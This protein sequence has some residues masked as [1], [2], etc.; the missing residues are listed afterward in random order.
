M[1]SSTTSAADVARATLDALNA[2]DIDSMRACWSES[3]TE[4]M[5]DGT[6]S[7]AD[8]LAAYFQGLVDALP[9]VS[10]RYEAVVEDGETV[11]LRWHLTGTHTGAPFQGIA[12]TGKAVA[13][14]GMDHMTIRDGK[15]V[16]NFVVFDRMQFAQQLGMMPPDG[17]GPEKAMKAAF[18]ART[19]LM[20][21]LAQ[22]RG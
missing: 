11:L 5:P 12:P 13:L 22:R 3:I 18:N 9:D 7:G 20:R 15:L 19:A 10:M 1:A 17:S 16:E 14:D 8:A 4:R 21:R 6:V 2:H